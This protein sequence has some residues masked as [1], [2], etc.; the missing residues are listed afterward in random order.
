MAALALMKKYCAVKLPA[1]YTTALPVLEVPFS[2]VVS[3]D[4]AQARAI[5][6]AP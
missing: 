6:A 5:Q 1:V 2:P 4:W 3:E